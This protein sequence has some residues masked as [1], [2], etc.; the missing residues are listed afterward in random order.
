M[1]ELPHFD[2]TRYV[3]IDYMHCILEG[4]CKDMLN[5]WFDEKYNHVDCNIKGKVREFDHKL[6]K[7]KL[8]KEFCRS[9]RSCKFFRVHYKASEIRNLWLYYLPCLSGLLKDVYLEHAF[10]MTQILHIILSENIP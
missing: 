7:I 1:A 9:P 10:I 8:P 2:L 4:I 5:M 6:L 3:V